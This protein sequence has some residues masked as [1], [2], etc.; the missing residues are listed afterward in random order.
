MNLTAQFHAML[1][2]AVS[3]LGTEL[4]EAHDTIATYMSE[5]AMHL[6]T[7]VAEPGFDQAVTAERNNVALRAGLAVDDAANAIDQ[8]LVGM[9]AGA[10][11]F[12]AVALA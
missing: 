3:D 12:A 11:R 10:L 9:I 5:R 7:I 6:S 4:E 2:A 1:N 8:Q